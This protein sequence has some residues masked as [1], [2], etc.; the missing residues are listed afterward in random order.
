MGLRRFGAQLAVVTVVAVLLSAAEGRLW[1]GKNDYL[2]GPRKG[3]LIS[4]YTPP[5]ECAT[6]KTG[7]FRRPPC[8]QDDMRYKVP[9]GDDSRPQKP[10]LLPV[11]PM[12]PLIQ[13]RYDPSPSLA[14]RKRL[15][16]LKRFRRDV[17]APRPIRYAL[18]GFDRV[19]YRFPLPRRRYQK[20]VYDYPTL[21]RP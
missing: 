18:P 2:A 7:E 19:T 4:R 1:A 9:T 21:C 12:P 10:T 14:Y 3:D 16:R 20:P 15:P 5:P 8:L 11:R 13:V 6:C 17:P